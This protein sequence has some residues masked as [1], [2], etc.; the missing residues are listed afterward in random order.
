MKK[1]NKE[2]K[3][4]R[5]ELA[6]RLRVAADAFAEVLGDASIWAHDLSGEME[7][8][9]DERSEKWQDGEAG[10]NY[11][12]WIEAF[13]EFAETETDLSAVVEALLNLPD[14]PDK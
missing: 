6:E 3:E 7:S 4:R 14:A 2:Q 10:Q 8:Y 11:E 9:R 1:L 5:D 12:S 13:T